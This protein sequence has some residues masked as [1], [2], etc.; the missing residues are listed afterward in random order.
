VTV[1]RSVN[2]KEKSGGARYCAVRKKQVV[3]QECI[4]VKRIAI[5]IFGANTTGEVHHMS[6]GFGRIY[7]GFV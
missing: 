6:V 7:I 4:S 1:L 2:A 3:V 5:I